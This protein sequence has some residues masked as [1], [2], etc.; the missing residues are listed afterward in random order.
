MA[1]LRRRPFEAVYAT[2][3]ILRP[4]GVTFRRKPGVTVSRSSYSLASGAALSAAVL[5]SFSLGIGP[6]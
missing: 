5:G 3:N 2:I 4:A 6:P 1:G